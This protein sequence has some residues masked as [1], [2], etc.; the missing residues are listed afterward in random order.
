[1][2]F[3]L[4]RSDWQIQLDR[5]EELVK[6]AEPSLYRTAYRLAGNTDDAKD[7]LQDSLIE[8]FKAFATFRPDGSFERWLLRIMTNTFIDSRRRKAVRPQTVGL[9][10]YY[11]IGEPG[12]EKDFPDSRPRPEDLA[13]ASEFRDVLNHALSRLP[14]EYRTALILC[15]MEGLSYAEAA[16]AMACPEGTVRSRLHRARQAVRR[17]LEPYLKGE[18][19]GRYIKLDSHPGGYSVKCNAKK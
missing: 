15:D 3:G 13:L 1:M 12:C 14:A 6:T 8:A 7:L 18:T 4:P 16:E 5:F 17:S 10:D 2:R 19:D 9:I 11:A